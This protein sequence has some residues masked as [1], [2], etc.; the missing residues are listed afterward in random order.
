MEK[1]MLKECSRALDWDLAGVLMEISDTAE[2]AARNLMMLHM[3]R[4]AKG[5]KW[6]DKQRTGRPGR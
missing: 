4:K 3:K 5:A 6:Y 2:R 1:Q